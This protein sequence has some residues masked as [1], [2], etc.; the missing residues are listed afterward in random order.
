MSIQA[1]RE[2]LAATSNEAKKLLA[3]KGDQKWSPEDQK[4][5][6]NLMDDCESLEA[7]IKAHEKLIEQDREE[8]FRDADEHRLSN[9]ERRAKKRTDS[10]IA[11]ENFVRKSNREMSVEEAHAVRNTMSTTTGTEGGFTV[12]TDVA[13]RIIDAAKAYAFM[14]A[15]AGQITTSQGNPLNYP[16]SD[17]TAEVGEWVAQ[18]TDAN[19]ADP[20]FGTVAL[21]VFKAGSKVVAVPIELLQDSSV[22][23]IGFIMARLGQR[24][25]R[26]SNIGYTTGD[27]LTMPR[28]LITAATVAKVGASGQTTTITYDD[29]V[30][31]SESV[32]AAYLAGAGLAWMMSQS[33]RKVV[34]KI[35][36]TSGRPIWVPSYDGGIKDKIPDELL[37]YPVRLN[38]DIAAPAANAKSLAFGDF[39]QYQ[40]RDALDVTI[41]RFDDSAY[42]KKGQVGFL[43]WARTGGNLLD[44]NAVKLY[45]QAAS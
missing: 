36:D 6:D 25:G 29:L 18:N 8:N 42:I 31:L 23:I 15:V 19:G 45:Q 33:M 5:F 24:I 2:R 13:T 30:D 35:K 39:S 26:I 11:F 40:I 28:G 3:D 27:G 44:A 20:S 32:D 41:F 38:N 37:G 16:T 12:Q 22:D 1:L 43:A 34:R 17:G 9:S 21:N 7:Q 10:D 4:K 14:R